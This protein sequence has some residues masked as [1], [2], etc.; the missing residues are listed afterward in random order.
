V[1][2]EGRGSERIVSLVDTAYLAEV[3]QVTPLSS[4]GDQD[5]VI[6]GRA[7]DRASRVSLPNTRV[8]LILN[9]QGFERIYS[10]LTD[11]SG[12]FVYIYKPTLS[13]AGLYKVSAVHPDITDRPEQK[14]FTINRVTVGPTP[15]KLD[16]PK[17]YPFTIPFT[18]RAGIGTSA[19]NLRLVLN[20]TSQP[21]GQIPAGLSL[22]LPAPL[23]LTERQ[24]LNLPVQFTAN[25]EAQPSGAL[26]LDVLSDE[27]ASTP[28]AQVRVDYRLSEA[29]PFLVSSPNFV[30]TGLSQGGSQMESVTI[31]NNGLQEALN[32]QFSLTKADGSPAPTWASIANAANG[33]LAVGQSR[34]IDLSFSPPSGTPEG[35]Y[36]FKLRVNGDNIP[37]QNLNVFVS[38]TQSGQGN[39]LFKA[40]N[41]YTATVGR[42]GRLIPGLAGANITLQ[43]E[44]VP[45]ISQELITDNLGEALFQNLPA[46]RYKFRVRASNH[47]ETG[48]RLFIKPSV[49]ANQSVFLNYNLITVEW[50]VREISIQ[51]RYEI[52]LNATFETDVPAAVVVMQ[53]TSINLP[54]MSAGDIYYGELSLT[55]YGLIRAEN[56]KQRLPQNDAY[57]RYEFLTEVPSTLEPKQRVTIPYRIIAIQSLGAAVNSGNASGGGCY[58]YTNRADVSYDFACANGQRASGSASSHWFSVSNSSCP[59]GTG[60]GGGGGGGGGVGRGGGGSWIDGGYSTPIRMKGKKCGYLPR[61]GMQCD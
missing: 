14:S 43:N 4:F 33:T 44:D 3:T 59:T 56:V 12:N 51:D 18:A 40:S 45:T 2:I 39:V 11:A 5:I 52:T 25:N 6:T 24:T 19:T 54:K 42:D 8:K 23:S 16:V 32:L 17:N 28:I 46:G 55:N 34:S 58:S 60:V 41:I 38:L 53:P 27:H 48:G 61:V 36:E 30:E 26:I 15:Y 29:K 50:S 7:L 49:T 13:D 10:V 20:P 57:F 21:T 9:Q 37:T 31:K 47:Q 35:V 1:Q 22:Q